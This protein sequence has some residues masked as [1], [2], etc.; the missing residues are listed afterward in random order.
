VVWRTHAQSLESETGVERI[1]GG[2]GIFDG[3][4]LRSV[5]DWVGDVR[6][7]LIAFDAMRYDGIAAHIRF[8]AAHGCDGIE[9]DDG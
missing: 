2:L 7:Y 3:G 4:R 8:R 9:L 5:R 1:I 6:V